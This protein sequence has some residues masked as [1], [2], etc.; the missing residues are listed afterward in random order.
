MKKASRIIHIAAAAL[1]ACLL[2][3]GCADDSRTGK[4]ANTNT[5][6]SVIEGQIPTTPGA[7]ITA[8]AQTTSPAPT[9]DAQKQTPAPAGDGTI[10]I[11]LTAMSSTMVYSEV[12]SMM[13]NPEAYLGKTVKIE[14]MYYAS[15]YEP[16]GLT[17]H[18]VVIADATACCSQGMEFIWNGEHAYPEDYP[19]D[20]AEVEIVGVFGT[21]DEL[22]Y[23]YGY[24]AVDDIVIVS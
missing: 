10:D 23:T 8:P 6:G 17:Y 19:P 13:E 9:P 20:G 4:P 21:Y 18:Y 5:V 7:E 2:F 22:G 3:V 1:A 16:T 11:D 15:F 12:F 14:G 24:L